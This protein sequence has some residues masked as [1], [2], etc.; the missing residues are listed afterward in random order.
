MKELAQGILTGV[1]AG[2]A[3]ST[4][5]FNTMITIDRNAK[6]VYL[7]FTKTQYADGYNKTMPGI[8]G[9][10]PQTEVLMNCTSWPRI[11]KGGQAPPRYCDF[12]NSGDK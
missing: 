12:S 6:R 9:K 2:V 11:R 1:P 7:P 10:V 3:A 4:S 5:C 8:C